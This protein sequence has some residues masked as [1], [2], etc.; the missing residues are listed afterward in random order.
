MYLFIDTPPSTSSPRGTPGTDGM[1]CLAL[2]RGCWDLPC[3]MPSTVPVSNPTPLNH[4]DNK[5]SHTPFQPTHFFPLFSFC[6][7]GTCHIS[8]QSRITS[9]P[10]SCNP[11]LPIRDW[12]ARVL[13]SFPELTSGFFTDAHFVRRTIQQNT[14][15]LTCLPKEDDSPPFFLT[16]YQGDRCHYLM[17]PA[18]GA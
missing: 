8:N 15:S 4:R 7:I 11:L 9:R 17:R 14:K 10:Q 5:D 16:T 3:C 12:I 6:D 13:Q 2:Y 18:K 1:P